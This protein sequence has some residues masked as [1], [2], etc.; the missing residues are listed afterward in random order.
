MLWCPSEERYSL[1]PPRWHIAH[2]YPFTI[3]L[4]IIR[5]QR[6][7]KHNRT[8]VSNSFVFYHSTNHTHICIQF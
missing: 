5:T 2:D 1:A 3:H 6:Y 4:N 7:V 8:G